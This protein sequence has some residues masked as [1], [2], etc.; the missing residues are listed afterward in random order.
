MSD[1][2]FERL[3]AVDAAFLEIET[4][5]AHP[6]ELVGAPLKSLHP[7]VPL[8]HHQGLGVALFSYDGTLSWGV[9]ADD[10]VVP[11]V[12]A[13]VDD[14]HAEFALLQTRADA[15]SSTSP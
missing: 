5:T 1:D 9:V 8:F 13:F 12:H 11:D 4:P 2:R 14:L 7:M 10:T 6:V 15:S 3:T